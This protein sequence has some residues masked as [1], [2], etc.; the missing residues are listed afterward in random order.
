MRK[1][2]IT[3]IIVLILLLAAAGLIITN[4]YTTLKKDVSDFSVQD[5]ASITKIFL[6]DKNN[7]EVTLERS[8]EGGW[9]VDGKYSAQQAK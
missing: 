9:L 6:A 2:R 8:P 7:N 3:L 4:S 1:N 5:T